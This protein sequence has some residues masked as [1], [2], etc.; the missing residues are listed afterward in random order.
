MGRFKNEKL[1]FVDSDR[2]L[3]A[4][5]HAGQAVDALCHVHW[6]GFS[7]FNLEHG[8]RA[9]IHAGPVAIALSLVDCYH[10]HGALILLIEMY[11]TK[12]D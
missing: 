4:V 11:E 5:L 7:G 2:L 12:R 10:H 9:H 1:D 8:L 6:F 3:R